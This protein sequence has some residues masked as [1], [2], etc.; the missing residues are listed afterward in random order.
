MILRPESKQVIPD[1]ARC[2][3]KGKIFEIFQWQQLLFDGTV[4]TFEKARRPDSVVVFPVTGTGG[5]LILQQEQP[6]RDLF[7]SGIGGRVEQGEDP[8]SAAKRELLEE[9]GLT[10]GEIILLNAFHPLVKVDW[11]VYTFIARG[12]IFGTNSLDSGERVSLL[13]VGFDAF[14]DLASDPTFSEGHIVPTLYKARSSQE[15][16]IKLKSLFWPSS[17]GVV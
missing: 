16:Y 12:L 10:T 6:G 2:V 15:E 5:V 14:L 4:A 7:K 8:V 13:E 3:F 17:N 9:A 11:V 1:Y